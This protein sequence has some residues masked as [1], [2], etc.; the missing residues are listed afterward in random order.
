MLLSWQR[1][2]RQSLP[3]WTRIKRRILATILPVFAASLGLTAGIAPA[4]RAGLGGPP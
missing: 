2:K 1:E 3:F 4:M